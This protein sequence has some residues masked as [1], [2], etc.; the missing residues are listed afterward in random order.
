MS[1]KDFTIIEYCELNSYKGVNLLSKLL[2][3]VVI[4]IPSIKLKF[5]NKLKVTRIE[6][7]KFFKH[8]VIPKGFKK[9]GNF[10]VLAII[11]FGTTCFLISSSKQKEEVVEAPRSYEDVD[12]DAGTFKP[13]SQAHAVTNISV[14]GDGL[15]TFKADDKSYIYNLEKSK[16]FLVTSHNGD[17]LEENYEVPLDDFVNLVMSNNIVM[18]TETSSDS[19]LYFMFNNSISLVEQSDTAPGELTN[20][21][22]HVEL[23]NVDTN[24]EDD[25]TE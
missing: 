22:D 17:N 12:K 19:D 20:V 9:K 7:S 8:L 1:S 13:P 16:F 4:K 15:L 21:K 10:I 14:K 24:N 11:V 3:K 25:T 2:N 23:D 5:P 18:F 6:I